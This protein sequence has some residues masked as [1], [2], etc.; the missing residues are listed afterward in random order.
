MSTSAAC[1]G[2]WTA[3]ARTLSFIPSAASGFVSVLL[4]RT[5]T[6]S[7][8]RLALI[9]IGVFSGTVFALLGYVYW[10]TTSY[11]H[12]RSDRAISADRAWLVQADDQAGSGAVA[13]LINQ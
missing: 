1:A 8:F 12:G 7:T 2:R 5:L 4:T 3:P 10:A 11:V 13:N 6:S 9:C